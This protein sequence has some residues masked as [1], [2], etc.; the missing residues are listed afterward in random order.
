MFLGRAARFAKKVSGFT[1]I[2][3]AVVNGT[4]SNFAADAAGVTYTFE[5]TSDNDPVVTVNIAA[6]VARDTDGIW[7]AAAEQLW[8]TTCGWG[9]TTLWVAE[10]NC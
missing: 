1:I 10:V 8:Y 9:S 5:A 4:V 3:I 2:D 6:G 7:N